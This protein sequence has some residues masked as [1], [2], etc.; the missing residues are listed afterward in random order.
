MAFTP[1]TWSTDEY[2]T[3]AKMNQ[4]KDS[5]NW[6]FAALLPALDDDAGVLK[7][8][9]NLGLY[10]VHFARIDPSA[11]N[12]TGS[13]DAT[14]TKLWSPPNVGF[15]MEIEWPDTIFTGTPMILAHTTGSET[16]WGIVPASRWDESATGYKVGFKDTGGDAYPINTPF[17]YTALVAGTRKTSPA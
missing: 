9:T 8:L 10:I 17:G 6:L 1:K 16:Q 13:Y 3:A 5:L 14:W 11:S 12:G 4:A 7:A 2:P 15:A